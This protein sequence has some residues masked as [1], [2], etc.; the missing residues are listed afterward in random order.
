MESKS[1]TIK[2]AK[3]PE[4]FTKIAIKTF[5]HQVKYNKV[6]H[7][8]VQNLGVNYLNV[9]RLEQI[10]FMPIEFFKQHTIKSG[11]WEPEVVFESSRT[12][13]NQP[14]LHPV[15]SRKHY[16]EHSLQLFESYYGPIDHWVVI[17]L[18]P[19]YL[20]RKGASLV[21]MV[22]YFMSKS[23]N[24]ASDFYLND[25]TKLEQ[26][27]G[28]LMHSNQ[29]VLL[30]GVTFALLDFADSYHG[31]ALEN[32][33]VMDTGGMKGR[34]KEVVKQEVITELKN[35]LGVSKVHSE[36][37]MTELLSQAYSFDQGRFHQN[38]SMQVLVREMN[39]PFS[40][41]DQGKTGGLNVIDLA[42]WDTCSFIETKDIGKINHDG[43]F[44]VLGRFDN[45]D[46]RGCN[47]MVL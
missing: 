33:T 41:V 28:D 18:L 26:T 16:L 20:E 10:P 34:K 24:K 13:G 17:G 30:F 19:S 23:K 12:T 32:V 31:R 5:K 37:G 4:Q 43:T 40:Y 45:S 46:I 2:N 6:Y 27:L 1:N 47:L 7:S 22:E 38:N 8:Y 15:R 11:N 21:H 39:D 35:K 36:Y 42:N 3:T 9:S 29:P 44:E 14:S 25:F